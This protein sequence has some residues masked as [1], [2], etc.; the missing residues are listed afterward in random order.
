[1]TQLT[2]STTD[3]DEAWEKGYTEGYKA[4]RIGNHNPP[5]PPRPRP[6]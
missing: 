3:A 4:S 6:C 5:I 2:I 1:M